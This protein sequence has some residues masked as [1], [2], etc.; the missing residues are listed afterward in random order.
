MQLS[1]LRDTLKQQLDEQGVYRTDAVL[2]DTLNEGYRT[3]A[4]LT[5][6]CELTK[7]FTYQAD[8]HFKYLPH[9]FFLPVAV[10]WNNTRLY[11]VRIAD[12]DRQ[13]V[14][15]MEDAPSEPLYYT[16]IGAL[17]QAPELWF[18]PRPEADATVRLTYAGIP[19][20]MTYDTDTPRL[21]SEHHFGVVWWGTAWELLKERG[22]LFVNKAYQM[23]M[24]FVQEANDLQQYM[25]RRTPDRDWIMPPLDMQ[26]VKRKLTNFEQA[27]QQ[28]AGTVEQRDLS[29]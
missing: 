29:Q 22:G 24:K 1:E 18:Y 23:Y 6:G 3:L 10:Y 27:Q 21:P 19:N 2:T 7:S 13:S 9:D 17:G 26:A 20:R 12:L 15:W 25:Y 8:R 16:T 4:L 11:P 28:Q 14:S 5:Q